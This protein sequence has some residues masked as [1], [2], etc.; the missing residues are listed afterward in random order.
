MIG[1]GDDDGHLQA[2]R[3]YVR[4]GDSLMPMGRYF[5]AL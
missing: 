3:F 2:R 5:K 1:P 4:A